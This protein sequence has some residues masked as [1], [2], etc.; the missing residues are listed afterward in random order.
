[1]N[2]ACPVCGERGI[3]IS[4]LLF[5]PV[6]CKFCRRKFKRPLLWSAL[7]YGGFYPILILGTLFFGIFEPLSWYFAA[8]LA[9]WVI[10]FGIEACIPL[11]EV[12][13]SHNMKAADRIKE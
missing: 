8:C 4:K 2:R 13:P 1:M 11:K 10:I 9:G 7:A 6:I 5:G 12:K 3:I